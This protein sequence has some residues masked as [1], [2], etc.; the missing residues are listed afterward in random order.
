MRRKKQGPPPLQILG[1]GAHGQDIRYIA[2]A[3][4]ETLVLLFDDGINEMPG[5]WRANACWPYVVGV[6]DPAARRRLAIGL[7][8]VTLIHPTATVAPSAVASPGVVIGAG[9]HVGPKTHLGEHVHIGPG[10]TLTRTTVGDFTT[11]SPGVDI[12]GDCTVGSGVLIGVGATIR[13]LITI[14]DNAV[15][16]AGA[17]VVSDVPAG[18]T[19]AGVPA[20]P[21][22]RRDAA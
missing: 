15:V 22:Q 2:H 5:T 11:I 14:G 8:P 1:Y 12:A 10:C 19:V 13:N 3:C 7:N 20:K 17:V 21:L 4:G 6:N 9:T 18:V 16:G